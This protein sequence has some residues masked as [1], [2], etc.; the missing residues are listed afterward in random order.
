MTN[1]TEPRPLAS[2]Y[3]VGELIG[4]GGMAEVHAG[5]DTRLNRD[6]AI[7]ILRSDLARDSSFILRFRREAQSAAALNHPSIVAMFDSGEQKLV[8]SGGAELAV[9]FIVMELVP[10][11]TLRQV[12]HEEGQLPPVKASQVIADTVR[13]LGYSHAHGIIHRD[14]KPAN[15]MLSDTGNVKVMD[16]GIARAI[17]DTAATMTNTA[18][19]IGTAQYLSP[20]QAQGQDVDA[21]SDL[22]SAG[23]LLYETLTGRTPFVGDSPVAVAYQHVGEPP[24][25]PSRFAEAVPSDLDAIV[26]HSLAKSPDERYQ[27]AE[28]MA[29]DLD[30]FVRGEP[31]SEAARA[32]LPGAGATE[33]DTDELDPPVLL[34][35]DEGRRPRA[36]DPETDTLPA[37]N[38]SPKRRRNRRLA[39][40]AAAGLAVLVALGV[41]IANDLIP[42]V[43]HVTVPDVVSLAEG[44]AT[45]RLTLEG[46]TA[47]IERETNQLPAGTVFEQDPRGDTSRPPESAVTLR[48]SSGPGMVR[49][50]DLANWDQASARQR[51]ADL[52]LQVGTIKQVDSVEVGAGNVS[53]T[54]PKSGNE[55][56]AGSTVTLLL[57]TGKTKVP[58]VVGTS[59]TDARTALNK[60]G[61]PVKVSYIQSSRR[62]GSVVSQSY[63]GERVTVGTTIDLRISRGIPKP[64]PPRTTT[65]TK[66]VKPTSSPTDDHTP[67]E[68][69]PTDSETS[70]SHNS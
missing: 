5:W 7:K 66:T 67:P 65:V 14:V 62:I 17:A 40:I 27:T 9:P 23:C 61:L 21:R 34:A 64:A 50:P 53:S 24:I 36:E 32:A 19:V 70:T 47:V 63:A 58:A 56:S 37:V 48:V 6:V 2:R 45:E 46:L 28:D 44:P 18:V 20:E 12:L 16:F 33:A 49:L 57:S 55:V 52:G 1:I 3:Q 15:V 8:E 51:L 29:A 11:R 68:D 13:A 39:M 38:P 30:R 31:V 4:R 42:S 60:V 41:L 43:R 59:E 54:D 10:G 35:D 26:L 22:Y 69:A 25:P